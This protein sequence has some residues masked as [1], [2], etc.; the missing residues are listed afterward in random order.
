VAIGVGFGANVAVGAAVAVG[1]TVAVFVGVGVGVAATT[2]YDWLG[3]VPPLFHLQK[4]RES[5]K[6]AAPWLYNG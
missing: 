2:N 6:I 3:T 5:P 1:V 4:K